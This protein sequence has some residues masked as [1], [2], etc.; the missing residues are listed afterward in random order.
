MSDGKGLP[1]IA[2]N[3]VVWADGAAIQ[4][5]FQDTMPPTYFDI[6]SVDSHCLNPDYPTEQSQGGNAG[7]EINMSVLVTVSG[8]VRFEANRSAPMQGFSESLILIPN[9]AASSQNTRERPTKEYVVQSQM[10][11]IVS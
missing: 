10:F 9:A 4:K 11:R 8:S 7:R 3:G 1:S 2:Y 5:A 6:Q